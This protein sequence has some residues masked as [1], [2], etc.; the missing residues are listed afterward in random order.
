MIP[1]QDGTSR[2][3]KQGISV[4]GHFSGVERFRRRGKTSLREYPDG[5][6]FAVHSATLSAE[7]AGRSWKASCNHSVLVTTNRNVADGRLVKATKLRRI[8]DLRSANITGADCRLT[9]PT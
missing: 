5:R 7:Q 9:H 6:T 2:R 4:D 1:R 3:R 8:A